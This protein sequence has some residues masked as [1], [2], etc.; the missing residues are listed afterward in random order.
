MPINSTA[1]KFWTFDQNNSG[2]VFDH[3]PAKGIGYA[4]CVEAVDKA[5]ARG[6]AQEISESYGASGDCPCCGERWSFYAYGDGDDEPSMYGKPL[7][8]GWGIPSYVHYLD[9]GIE[10]REVAA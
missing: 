10:A 6:R 9:G 3:N 4:I 2:G 8:G 5:H 7:E 1:T